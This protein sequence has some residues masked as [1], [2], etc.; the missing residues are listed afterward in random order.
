[1][2][3]KRRALIEHI[4]PAL[5]SSHRMPRSITKAQ[6]ALNITPFG[7]ISAAPAFM[8]QLPNAKCPVPSQRQLLCD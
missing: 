4:D 6:L 1:V 2:Q 7:L 8:G 3:K 5:V